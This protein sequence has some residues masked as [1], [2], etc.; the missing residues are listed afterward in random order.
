MHLTTLIT[1]GKLDQLRCPLYGSDGCVSTASDIDVERF[2]CCGVA[3][4]FK[5]FRQM[6][7]HPELRECPCCSHLCTPRKEG[8]TVINEMVC[9]TCAT[10]FCFLHSSAHS[11]GPDAC[12]KYE[13]QSV[14]F[15]P[16]WDVQPCPGCGLLSTR[17]EGCVRMHCH[18]GLDWCWACK[19]PVD[20]VAWHYN[21]LR[22]GACRLDG[23]VPPTRVNRALMLT[24]QVIGAPAYVI[25]CCVVLPVVIAHVAVWCCFAVVLCFCTSSWRTI[26]RRIANSLCGPILVVSL[27]VLSIIE[28]VWRIIVVLLYCCC[29]RLLGATWSEVDFLQRIP[30]GVLGMVLETLFYVNAA[31]SPDR[32]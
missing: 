4:K 18:C 20:N 11:P 5:R 3:N 12:R 29:L 19:Q 32:G 7:D 30:K 31:P 26:S 21:P 2:A 22:T 6:R 24:C 9:E 16:T 23:D 25:S 17:V 13:E 27:I 8:K 15:E 10:E 1:D 14:S 28:V